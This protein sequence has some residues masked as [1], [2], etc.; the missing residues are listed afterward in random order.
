MP[1]LLT[2]LLPD[3]TPVAFEE[4]FHVHDIFDDVELRVWEMI[5]VAIPTLEIVP[6]GVY[7]PHPEEKNSLSGWGLA[8][9]KHM[10]LNSTEKT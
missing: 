1:L 2:A 7:L 3:A 4:L 5:L 8:L 9:Q 6:D 10:Q